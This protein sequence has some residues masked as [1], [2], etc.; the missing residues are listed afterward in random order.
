M[1]CSFGTLSPDGSVEYL[2]VNIDRDFSLWQH[3]ESESGLIA[4]SEM[5]TLIDVECT[6]NSIT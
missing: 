2:D 5:R 6:F 3:D 1:F 4:S